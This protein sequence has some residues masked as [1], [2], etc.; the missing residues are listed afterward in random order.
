MLSKRDNLLETINGGHPDRFVK[1]YEAFFPLQFG[2]PVSVTYSTNPAE[3]QFTIPYGPITMEMAPG[4]PGP[5]PVEGPGI[6]V[7]GHIDDLANWRDYVKV[8]DLSRIPE[9]SFGPW[10]D[11]VTKCD[12][13]QQF[14]TLMT[15]PG[16]LDHIHFM[17]GMQEAMVATITDPDILRAM[18]EQYVDYLS[19]YVAMVVKRY[20]IEVVHEHDD[21]G[22][23]HST[24]IS[25]ATFD[26]ILLEPYKRLHAAYRDA[27]VQVIIHHSDTFAATLVPELIEMDTDI[28]Q[29]C[30]TSNDLP[31]IK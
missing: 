21:W 12:T 5:M 23:K 14:L 22:S 6:T 27:G 10:D 18:A 13:S 3:Y 20:G 29:G 25:K 4:S 1:R 17:M 2:D 28:W 15:F 8:P 24:L 30:L 9:Q 26:E 16:L 19:E 7:L 11:L 31:F